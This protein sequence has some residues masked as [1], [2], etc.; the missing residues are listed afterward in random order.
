MATPTYDLLD[1]T[2]LASSASSVTFSSISQ[3]YRDLILIM[4]AKTTIASN[5]A[6][7]V[8]V[9]GDT[10]SNYFGVNMYGN[11]SSTGSTS[12]SSRGYWYVEELTGGPSLNDSIWIAQFLDYSATDKHKTM[13]YR[14]GEPSVNVE[15]GAK[16]WASTA[17]ITSITLDPEAYQL[18]S[19]STFYLYGI[20]S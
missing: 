8:T 20:A 10:G 7:R 1:S 19:G 12:F 11:G 13:L 9:N 4:N 16:R 2:T 17:A 6:T 5:D 14:W 18:A 3:D 15:A